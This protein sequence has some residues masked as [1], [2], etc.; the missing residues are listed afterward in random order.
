MAVRRSGKETIKNMQPMIQVQNVSFSYK[1]D[2]EERVQI[3][4]DFNLE[5]QQGSFVAVLGHNGSG[6]S[7]LARLL[8]ALYQPDAGRVLVNG[9]DTSDEEQVFAVRRSVG[10]VFQNPDNQLV[11]S[12]VEEDVAF[13]PEN[14][15]IAPDEIRRRVDDALQAV[16]MY[17][18][19]T[20]ETHKL[21]GGQK[22]RIAIAGILAMQP[23]CIVFDEPTAM[24]DPRGR[25]EVMDI[26]L[27]L[28]REM[29]KTII[30]ITHYM[31]EAAQAQR[32]VV[33]DNGRIIA[34]DTPRIVFSKV[35][36]LKSV[37]LDVPQPAELSDRLRKAGIPL[38]DHVLTVE[39][40]I[41]AITDCYFGG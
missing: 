10:L 16:D 35:G 26:I 7:T 24:L 19:R 9:L 30:L 29:G 3:L 17:E 40:C 6:K 15:G 23:D 31:D 12:I 13:G 28:N 34:D 38:R 36:L 21:S 5:I 11:A 2:D 41:S 32:V 33:M 20:H 27:K 14:L 1:G 39:E 4:Q 8:N 22:Q 37:G 18:Y 25:K